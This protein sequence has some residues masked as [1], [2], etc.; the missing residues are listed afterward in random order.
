MLL[1][2]IDR[3]W[4]EHLYEMDYL[5]EGV[6][7][8]AYAQRD[9]LVEYQREGFDMFQ[10]MLDGIKEEAV[11]F[12]FN[13]EVQV[14][15]PEVTLDEKPVEI[16]A[17]GLGG[18]RLPRNLQYSAPTID[19]AAGSG[20][21]AV[22]QQDSAPALG[23]GV[24]SGGRPA[25][26]GTGG[27]RSGARPSRAGSGSGATARPARSGGTVYG[28]GNALGVGGNGSGGSAASGGGGARRSGPASPTAAGARKPSPG[29]A[30]ATGGPSRTAPCYCGSGKKY[31]RCHGAPGVA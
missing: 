30:T 8:R 16:H 21:V 24:E 14:E 18:Q 29:Q 26:A 20:G 31:K 11:G 25:G 6:D 23:I 1:A 13:L 5:Q 19:G 3:K 9:P 22:E 28:S 12:L 2:V 17:K 4:R 7:L 15:E 27:R 10:Q